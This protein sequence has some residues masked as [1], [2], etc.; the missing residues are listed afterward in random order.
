VIGH[1]P[2]E[3]LAG[4]LAAAIGVM[5]QRIGLASAPDRHDQ[6]IGDELSRHRRAH[7]PSHGSSREEIEDGGHIEPAFRRPDV[8]KISDP[9]AVGRRGF[10]GAVQHVGS[11]GAGL[12]FTQVG[13]Q[14]DQAS[15][16]DPRHLGF[17][18]FGIQAFGIPRT[19][20]LPPEQWGTFW[21]WPL[22]PT[23]LLS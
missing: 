20:R 2:L 21:K 1:Q 6:R 12:P 4:V 7:R 10:E 9:F 19:Y 13:R 8:R 14:A 22:L 3:L 23:W 11:D 15:G 17:R 18:S 5:Q 16:G